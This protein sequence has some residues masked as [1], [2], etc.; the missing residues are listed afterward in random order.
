MK[1]STPTRAHRLP[2]W[3]REGALPSELHIAREPFP[4]SHG[5]FDQAMKVLPWRSTS[6]TPGLS[7]DGASA[8]SFEKPSSFDRGMRR[9]PI[10]TDLPDEELV[11]RLLAGD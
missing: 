8:P 9:Q 7:P 3:A 1:L 6:P 5:P 4:G 10:G 11:R 2:S